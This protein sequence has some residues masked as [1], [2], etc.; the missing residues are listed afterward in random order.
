M[1]TRKCGIYEIRNKT[2]GHFY[3][4]SSSDI[5]RRFYIHHYLLQNGTHHNIHLQRA[6][7]KYGENVFEFNVLRLVPKESCIS[8]EQKLLTEHF[9]K[10]Y[11]YNTDRYA[12]LNDDLAN[13]KRSVSLRGRKR[14]TETC[15]RMSVA[16]KNRKI[17]QK[18]I[19]GRVRSGE[20][21]KKYRAD[22]W[23]EFE[24]KRIA[25]CVGRKQS[26]HFRKVMSEKMRGRIITKEW[27]RHISDAQKGVPKPPRTKEHQEKLNAAN[28]GLKRSKETCE[29]LRRSLLKYYRN[30][31]KASF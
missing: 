28:R 29:K 20:A 21:L 1:E 17:T 10:R 16:Q 24:A 15:Q 9:G 22:H 31:K 12:K 14:S 26:E 25:A 3:I 30:K 6:W 13:Q 4:G 7:K 18:V 5:E 11:F 27:R 8:E 2:N 19:D 23:E